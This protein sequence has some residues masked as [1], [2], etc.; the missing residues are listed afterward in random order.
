MISNFKKE[1]I[2]LV[3]YCSILSLTSCSTSGRGMMN[4]K[5]GGSRNPSG[6]GKNVA[7]DRSSQ[8]HSKKIETANATNKAL[9]ERLALCKKELNNLKRLY[10]ENNPNP[11]PKL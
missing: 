2:G 8:E 7:A 9:Q 4:D 11:K 10:N 3:T 5:P 6:A 1:L